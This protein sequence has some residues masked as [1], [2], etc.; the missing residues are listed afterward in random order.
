MDARAKTVREIL[1]SGDQYL[2]PLFQRHYSWTKKHWDRLWADIRALE[3]AEADSQHFLG[4][5]VC[6]PA[7]AI[8]GEVPAFQL[9]DG[10]QRLTTL[11]ILLAALRDVARERG[12][13]SL[14]DEIYED[15]LVHKRKKGTDRYKVLPRLHDRQPLERVIEGKSD[16]DLAEY[17]VF[18]AWRYFHRLVGTLD[19]EDV[20]RRLRD[21]FVVVS[22]RLSLVVITIDQENPY[23]IFESLNSTGLPL[24]ESDLIRNFVFMQVPLPDQSAFNREHWSP[25]EEIFKLNCPDAYPPPTTFYRNYLMRNGMYSRRRSTFVDFKNEYRRLEKNPT[26]QIEELARFAKLEVQL[27]SPQICDDAEMRARLHQLEQL[28]ITTAYPLVMHLMD[29]QVIGAISREELLECLTDLSSFVLRRS[30]CGDS[31]RAYGR[32]FTEAIKALGDKPRDN[33]RAYLQHRGWPDDGAFES[34][35]V[36]FALYQRESKK[37]RLILEE[38]ERAFGHKEQVGF[39]NLTIEHVMPQK[40]TAGSKGSDWQAALGYD[41][42]SEHRR[43]VHT[44]G[45]LTLTGYNTELSNRPFA[46]KKK[47]LRESNVSLN[48]YFNDLDQWDP[49]EI[50]RRG[51]KLAAQ[52]VGF[53]PRPAGGTYVPPFGNTGRAISAEQR[54]KA[55]VE[56]WR[57]LIQEPVLKEAFVRLPPAWEKRSLHFRLPTRGVALAVK[58]HPKKR[59]ID[60]FLRLFRSEHKERFDLL[61]EQKPDVEKEM[62]STLRWSTSSER[63]SSHVV[64]SRQ[65]VNPFDDTARDELTEWIA[66][67]LIQLKEVA[68]ERLSLEEDDKK[69]LSDR[70]KTQLEYWQGVNAF[71]AEHDGDVRA[72][73][74]RPQPW[75]NFGMGVAHFHMHAAMH[76]EEKWIRAAVT[77]HATKAKANFS[78]LLAMR[79]EIEAEI[80]EELEW[81]EMPSRKESR[82]GLWQRGTD[83]FDRSDWPRQHQWVVEKLELLRD[84]FASRMRHLNDLNT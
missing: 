42:K 3:D 78:K 59:T 58:L 80:G 60:V 71:L 21:I 23:E 37:C 84:V 1:H 52:I 35:L 43:W 34:R 32:W 73:K 82:I 33:L 76:V 68:T 20:E 17:G 70:R 9:I 15:Y 38:L 64:L 49:D 45:N 4:P 36:E 40:I 41:W 65:G 5:L 72:R 55:C 48:R 56:F 30:I 47:A 16:R 77:C 57:S 31:T 51:K 18:K 8:P 13:D 19:G 69:G 46:E 81:E 11:S 62:G 29:R 6:T 10:Q 25:F 22:G 44:I 61:F 2:I 67:K 27:R 63:N 83:P 7:R 14:A 79:S 75:M 50:A 26:A 74:P 54:R 53:W 66:Q 12:F 39:G 28:D 24:E